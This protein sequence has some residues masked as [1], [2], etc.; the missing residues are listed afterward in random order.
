MGVRSRISRNETD[1]IVRVIAPVYAP[2]FW[3]ESGS[4][5]EPTYRYI[6]LEYETVFL[7]Y[8]YHS[9]LR[10]YSLI[11]FLYC[12]KRLKCSSEPQWLFRPTLVKNR[13]ASSTIIISLF[14]DDF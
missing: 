8:Q 11:I 7:L 13:D 14:S 5:S 12:F 1:Q 3:K 9:N 4:P 2:T 6:R 10:I